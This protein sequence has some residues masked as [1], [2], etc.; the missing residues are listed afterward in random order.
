MT[1]AELK[2]HLTRLGNPATTDEEGAA[3]A[4]EVAGAVFALLQRGVVALENLARS[5][6][7]QP[8]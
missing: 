3:I 1:E 8:D 7:F 2:E 4:A 5:K 6:G